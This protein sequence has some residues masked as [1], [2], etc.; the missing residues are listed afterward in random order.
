MD[1]ALRFNP[2]FLEPEGE[3]ETI[4]GDFSID[5]SVGY[6][7][8]ERFLPFIEVGYTRTGRAIDVSYGTTGSS[9][10]AGYQEEFSLRV[11]TVGIGAR[12]FILPEIT[13]MHV[14]VCGKWMLGFANYE[15]RS[16]FA[17]PYP[18][19]HT[20]DLHGINAGGS[21]GLQCSV[22]ISRYF[23]ILLSSEYR[24][25]QF[26]YLSGRGSVKH[27]GPQGFETSREYGAALI[28][29]RSYFGPT[30]ENGMVPS[31]PWLRIGDPFHDKYAQIKLDGFGFAI[32]L[33]VRI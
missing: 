26:R 33:E 24:L 17:Q 18:T 19:I 22:D 4:K 10:R 28:E 9:A 29:T 27:L 5:G 31:E 7:L 2:F 20:A 30:D 1:D 23:S 13:F 11:F 15:Y 3:I 8:S 25:L 21:L 12:Y 14:Y 16:Q 6:S 32:G